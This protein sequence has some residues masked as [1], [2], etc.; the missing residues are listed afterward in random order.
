M[1]EQNKLD[2][3]GIAIGGVIGVIIGAVLFDGF[4]AIAGFALL[5]AFLGPALL[6]SLKG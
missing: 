4:G 2:E 1:S 3:Q 6:G 5:G